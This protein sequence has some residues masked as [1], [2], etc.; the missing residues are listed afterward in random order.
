VEACGTVMMLIMAIGFEKLFHHMHHKAEHAFVYGQTL[1]SEHEKHEAVSRGAF[2]KPLRLVL[3]ARMGGEFMVLGFLASVIWV[4]NQQ[5]LFDACAKITASDMRLPTTGA[6]YL[7]MM[8]E[9]H[10]QLFLAMILYFSGLENGTCC[11]QAN[12]DV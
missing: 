9:V 5:G 11:R 8:E 2:T 12:P 3:F 4:S 10:M 7:H 1:L 6:D